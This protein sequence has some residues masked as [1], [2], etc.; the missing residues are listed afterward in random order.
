MFKLKPSIEQKDRNSI[1]ENVKLN[2]EKLV[3][4][5]PE[6][7]FYEVGINISDSPA[8]YDYIINSEFASMED[9]KKYSKHPAH[10][11]AV[12]FNR[13]YSDSKTVVDYQ[14]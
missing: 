3:E 2:F 11:E 1:L 9:L 5:I 6:I 12:E 4:K 14:F 13:Q 10:I 8:A 7:I